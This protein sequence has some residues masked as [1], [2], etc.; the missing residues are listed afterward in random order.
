[1]KRINDSLTHA[2]LDTMAREGPRGKRNTW[3]D[4]K[5]IICRG[6]VPRGSGG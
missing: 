2:P 5:P 4:E 1:M 3:G 6:P